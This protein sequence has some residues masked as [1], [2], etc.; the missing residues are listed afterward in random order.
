[1]TACTTSIADVK[2]Q[3]NVGKKVTVSGTVEGSLK[4]GEISGYTLKDDSGS[5]FISS[6]NLPDDGTKKTIR[7][8]LEKNLIG[9]YVET[10]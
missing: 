9:Y 2:I 1:M 3:D 8:L 6:N 5:I 4:L 7:G 10:K